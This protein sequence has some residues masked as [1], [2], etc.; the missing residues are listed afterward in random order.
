MRRP[1][2]LTLGA[3]AIVLMALSR[4]GTPAEGQ[5]PPLLLDEARIGPG[6]SRVVGRTVRRVAPNLLSL[7]PTRGPASSLVRPLVFGESSMNEELFE[8]QQSAAVLAGGGFGVVWTRGSYP[9][10]DVWMQW[11]DANGNA[12]L[13]PGG[14]L[15]AGGPAEQSEVVIAARPGAGAYVAFGEDDTI[16]VQSYD[17]SGVRRWPAGGVRVADS[18]PGAWEPIHSPHLI[19]SPGGVFVCFAYMNGSIDDIRCQYLDDGGVRQWGPTGVS[20][21]NGGDADLRVLPRGTSDGTGGILL[22]WRNMRQSYAHPD[23]S[24]MLMEG[25]HFDSQGVRLWGAV[26]KVVRTTRLA[27]TN[28]YGY[29]Y[30]QVASDGDGGAVLAFNDWAGKDYAM[31]V[32]A[33]RVS[34]EGDLLW[35]DGAIVTAAPGHQ[36]HQQTI[37]AG[38]GGAFVAVWDEINGDPNRDRLLL[39][40]L[41]PDGSQAWAPQ[42]LLLSD[43][44]SSALDYSV[45]GSFDGRFLRIGWTHQTTYATFEMDVRYAVYDLQGRRS[46]GPAGFPLTTAPDGQYLGAL[47]YSPLAQKVLAAWDDRRKHSWDDMDVTG[48]TLNDRF[49]RRGPR[50]LLSRGADVALTDH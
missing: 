8:L 38:D 24:P 28:G 47:V 46:G 7:A 2:R 13:A 15:V 23:D 26:P 21:G 1:L 10:Y 45:H 33:Q 4:A 29:D 44:A 6:A 19:A 9:N 40:R 5:T 30:F 14:V 34:P 49:V 37:G 12:V 25:Q 36:Q 17:G 16:R 3:A 32:M 22:F 27:S 48:A 11:L 31:D 43:P 35:G 18:A 50:A 41:R 20:V 42:G 39:F